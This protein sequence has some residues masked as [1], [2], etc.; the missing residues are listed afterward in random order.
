MSLPRFLRGFQKK[1]PALNPDLESPSI[2]HHYK[3]SSESDEPRD[4][5]G[6]PLPVTTVT[7]TYMIATTINSDPMDIT[8]NE[9]F[10]PQEVDNIDV[11][12][13]KITEN[14]DSGN[15][16][17][18]NDNDNNQLSNTLN[19]HAQE[20][21]PHLSSQFSSRPSSRASTY[22]TLQKN[23]NENTYPVATHTSI[24]LPALSTSDSLPDIIMTN[25]R[26]LPNQ[27]NTKMPT[28]TVGFDITSA[29]T[30]VNKMKIENSRGEENDRKQ[31]YP[32]TG[33]ALVIPDSSTIVEREQLE[34]S[35][36]IPTPTESVDPPIASITTITTITAK[37]ESDTET[38]STNSIEPSYCVQEHTSSK[39][40]N[41]LQP[42]TQSKSSRSSRSRSHSNPNMNTIQPVSILKKDPRSILRSHSKPRS[43]A[44]PP[45]ETPSNRVSVC[46]NSSSTIS[47]NSLYLQ[48][49]PMTEGRDT[50]NLNHKEMGLRGRA[51]SVQS[52][53]R[54]SIHEVQS[55]T[56]AS[57][58][59]HTFA[60]TRQ[61]MSPTPNSIPGSNSSGP[62]HDNTDSELPPRH[63]PDSLETSNASNSFLTFPSLNDYKA[64]GPV[65]SATIPPQDYTPLTLKGVRAAKSKHRI[66]QETQIGV[67]TDTSARDKMQRE[68]WMS[69]PPG[70]TVSNSHP[71]VIIRPASSHAYNPL[72]VSPCAS[73]LPIAPPKSIARTNSSKQLS[74]MN[75]ASAQEHDQDALTPRPRQGGTGYGPDYK[76][77]RQSGGPGHLL[78]TLDTYS[79]GPDL[80]SEDGDSDMDDTHQYGKRLQEQYSLLQRSQ[81]RQSTTEGSE[82]TLLLAKNSQRRSL[83]DELNAPSVPEKSIRRKRVSTMG[84]ATLPRVSSSLAS[85]YATG[86]ESLNSE[87][88]FLACVARPNSQKPKE[89]RP[90]GSIGPNSLSFEPLFTLT[91]SAPK[92]VNS[93][94]QV[95]NR[96]SKSRLSAVSDADWYTVLL[97]VDPN[98]QGVSILDLSKRELTE[99]PSDLP[100]TITH[101]RLAHNPIRIL[102]P[103]NALTPLN[104]LQVLDLCDIQLGILPPEIGLLTRLKELHLSNNKLWKLPDSIQKMARLEVLDIR[105]N[106]FYLLNPVIGRLK[107]L[108]QL[109][110]RNNQLKSLPAQLCLLSSTLTVLLVDGNQFVQ[111]FLDLLQPLM[112]D[113]KDSG[114]QSFLSDDPYGDS[115][116]KYSGGSNLK[117]TNVYEP[118]RRSTTPV[119]R[120]G[121]GSPGLAKR[122]SHGDLMSLI[123]LQRRDDASQSGDILSELADHDHTVTSSG[124]LG[125]DSTSLRRGRSVSTSTPTTGSHFEHT[126][127]SSHTL[128]F[129]KF[130]K[131][132]RKSSKSALKDNQ[133]STKPD[134]KKRHSISSEAGNQAEIDP[135][136][137]DSEQKPGSKG[138]VSGRRAAHG[139][140]N[141]WV[142]DRFHKSAN[143]SE[144]GVLS[145]AHASVASLADRLDGNENYPVRD[146]GYGGIGGA[147]ASS[148][149]ST[150]DLS[151]T[152]LPKKST[153]IFE[154]R[155]QNKSMGHLPYAASLSPNDSQTSA[156]NDHARKEKGYRDSYISV[157]SQMTQGTENESDVA[158]LD[159]TIASQQ[160]RLSSVHSPTTPMPSSPTISGVRTSSPRISQWGSANLRCGQSAAH[161]KPLIQYLK[162]LFDLDPDSSEWEEVHAWRRVWNGEATGTGISTA[163]DDDNIEEEEEGDRLVKQAKN[164]EI[165]MAKLKAQA[166]RRRRIVDEIMTTERTYVEGLKGLVEIYLTPALQIMQPGDHKAIFS[167]AQSIYGFHANHFL[168]ELEKA[169]RVQPQEQSAT[170]LPEIT[171]P[172]SPLPTGTS[173]FQ[174][175]LGDAIGD[176]LETTN[177]TDKQESNDVQQ[178]ESSGS[179]VKE[180]TTPPS[181]TEVTTSLEPV[182][183]VVEDRIGRVFAEHVAYMKMYSFYINNYDN[184]L[185]VLQTQ[186]TSKHKKKMKEFLRRCAKHPNHTQ[187]TIQGYLL[188]PI[189]RI[190]RYKMLLQDL[191]DNT[192]P[193]HVDYQDIATALEMIS[194]RADEMN[195]RKRQHENHEKVLLVQNRIVG[196][197]KTE[198]VQPYRKVVREGMLHLIRVV[199]R[200]V[201]MGVD[202]VVIQSTTSGINLDGNGGSASHHQ[203]GDLTVHHLSEETVEKSYIFILFNDIL[204]QCSPITSKSSGHA[205]GNHNGQ[206]TLHASHSQA[207][208]L[209]S[210]STSANTNMEP[211]S[212]E[213]RRVLQLESRLH[214]AEIIGQDVL[215]VVDDK[216]I[217]YLTGDK[218]VIQSWKE[219]INARW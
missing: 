40:N 131:S 36:L 91:D 42:D 68:S 210:G 88:D 175:A 215:R 126:T 59:S 13:V 75:G 142:R 9:A 144:I 108:R 192:W 18:N 101:L 199:T 158:D 78:Y 136:V 211:K 57:L 151:E 43:Q 145:D 55:A 100:E 213:L 89:R 86:S 163:H 182:K 189:Q 216:M 154:N 187:L 156:S 38:F 134:S 135:D 171:S 97:T 102:T 26:T 49:D 71:S 161:I 168:P 180:T 70:V 30:E 117:A 214:P 166:S 157:E 74:K 173:Y 90:Y 14:N 155:F 212:L 196:N 79:S 53:R 169:Y 183:M 8:V 66:R 143:S 47:R 46:S 148:L 153:G 81:S 149:G 72:S 194:A 109:D 10:K 31:E 15:N 3:N 103:M 185:R 119:K 205:S 16:D 37:L 61:R 217:L 152:L 24:T 204:I 5:F 22:T 159:S 52:Q 73:P 44:M 160:H 4:A 34:R 58:T 2:P 107:T 140:I 50:D 83:G 95:G 51:S 45:V 195:E 21:D 209:G 120:I 198:L 39:S 28:I 122:R 6:F 82:N 208:S 207:G 11:F 67:T 33:P 32:N 202:K 176:A 48:Q 193:E 112:L 17:N 64:A 19:S 179:D 141:Q 94:K 178:T 96:D 172:I 146:S 116:S 167:N 113:D 130:L 186:L 85:A 41:M 218:D 93:E 170:M 206:N 63:T 132:I 197:Y 69:E 123:G 54:L 98:Q 125:S 27:P 20:K 84:S 29:I 133:A 23:T 200:N 104:H 99:I 137:H 124:T 127:S 1:S 129:N 65:S 165:K 56:P 121:G 162:D 114:R 118:W 128:S 138:S 60:Q 80:E 219:D 191:L 110:V 12:T 115:H 87:S 190:P 174:L 92:V 201:V 150:P 35:I 203:L 147:G 164:E 25:D 106:Q 7:T 111:P 184:S 139:G 76:P 181:T 105:N 188:L 77:R 177:S 62:R